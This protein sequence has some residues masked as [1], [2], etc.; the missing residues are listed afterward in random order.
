[1]AR[2]FRVVS[3]RPERAALRSTEPGSVQ[4]EAV[5]PVNR[6]EIAPG[7]AENGWLGVLIPGAAERTRRFL[8]GHVIMSG[9]VG[10]TKVGSAFGDTTMSVPL[11]AVC[12][13]VVTESAALVPDASLNFQ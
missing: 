8:Q 5:A 7:H 4:E 1:M 10:V 12:P 13:P 9:V 2:S 3:G 6:S 11:C